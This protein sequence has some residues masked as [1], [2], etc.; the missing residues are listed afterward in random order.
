MVT[1]IYIIFFCFYD[2]YFIV[3]ILI[4]PLTLD[5]RLQKYPDTIYCI[6]VLPENVLESD[7]VKLVKLS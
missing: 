6:A 4:Q 3:A 1:E 7:V 2:Y 5:T